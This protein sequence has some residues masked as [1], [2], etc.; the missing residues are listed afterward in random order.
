[1]TGFAYS[2]ISE[3]DVDSLQ[4]EWA[5]WL[6]SVFGSSEALTLGTF[7]FRNPDSKKYPGWTAPGQRYVRR[8]AQKLEG[9]LGANGS[10]YVVVVEEGSDTRRLHLH[11]L[12]NSDKR[13]MRLSQVWWE[14]DQ[15]FVALRDVRSREG[16]SMYV[17]KYIV[18]TP[19][20]FYAGGPAFGAAAES[21]AL[22]GPGPAP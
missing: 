20:M 4:K 14:R 2:Y 10:S 1:M 21:V 11:S 22:K 8:A 9:F 5:K 6:Q 19:K 7:T 12:S 15:G 3:V 18:K 17:T 16:V 13:L